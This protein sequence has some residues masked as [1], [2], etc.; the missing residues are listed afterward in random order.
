MVL[1]EPSQGKEK[2][3]RGAF[4]IGKNQCNLKKGN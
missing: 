2:K 4:L 3:G 1:I